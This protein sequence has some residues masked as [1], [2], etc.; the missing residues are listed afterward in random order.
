M[1]HSFKHEHMDIKN[2]T[3]NLGR[4][5][6]FLNHGLEFILTNISHETSNPVDTGANKCTIEN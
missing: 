6:F 1:K 5:D 3:F 2:D 4:Y